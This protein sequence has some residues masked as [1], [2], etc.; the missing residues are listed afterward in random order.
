MLNHGKIHKFLLHFG[1]IGDAT[2]RSKKWILNNILYNPILAEDF[3]EVVYPLLTYEHRSQKPVTFNGE[4]VEASWSGNSIVLPTIR[5]SDSSGIRIQYLS[6][7]GNGDRGIDATVGYV[8]HRP[9][10]VAIDD[11]QSD[12][13]AQSPAMVQKMA[14][15]IKSTIEH[16]GGFRGKKRAKIS[17]AAILTPICPG[18][19]SDILMDHKV[20]PDYRGERYPLLKSMPKRMDLWKKYKKLRIESLDQYDDERLSEQF[21]TDNREEMDD[22]LVSNA[23]S[24]MEEGDH[25]AGQYAMDLWCSDARSF[26]AEKMLDSSMSQYVS[27]SDLVPAVVSG[28]NNLLKPWVVPSWTQALTA[29]I[30]V[31]DHYLC[32]EIVAFGDEYESA[33]TVAFGWWPDQGTADVTKHKPVYSIQTEYD[34]KTVPDRIENAIKDCLE[35]IYNSD[36][37]TEQG[38][39]VDVEKDSRFSHARKKT[40]FPF[41]A[42]I[43]IDAGGSNENAVWNAAQSFNSTYHAI[44]LP[45]YGGYAIGGKSMGRYLLNPSEGEWSRGYVEAHREWIENPKRVRKYRGKFS[46]V[47]HALLYDVNVFKSRRLSAWT[48]ASEQA[49]SHSIADFP[50]DFLDTY[51]KHLC[52]EEYATVRMRDGTYYDKW[53]VREGGGDNEFLDTNT[54]CWALADYIGIEFRAE[55]NRRG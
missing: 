32:Y 25:S 42:A 11:P 12:Q 43:G 33:H 50:P 51:S 8:A 1:A 53:R 16:L 3:P 40:R 49:G 35:F 20:S 46:H 29:H 28:K 9:S 10:F 24:E 4:P 54:A 22:G 48:L 21:Y 31:G 45:L 41:L 26:W 18:D 34:G 36:Y 44:A 52:S 6:I 7:G 47:K 2:D 13:S 23:P 55:L 15:K 30:D 19:L 37:V 17:V 27:A 5:G 39:P 38:S 14:R